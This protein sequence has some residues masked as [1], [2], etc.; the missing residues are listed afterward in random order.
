MC[1]LK[2]GDVAKYIL[3]IKSVTKLELSIGEC[4]LIRVMNNGYKPYRQ[5]Q[6]IMI[7]AFAFNTDLEKLELGNYEECKRLLYLPR[8]IRNK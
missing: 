1:R 3:G 7:E 6:D 4:D 5:S 2:L 8:N